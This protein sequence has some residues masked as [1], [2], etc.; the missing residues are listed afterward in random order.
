MAASNY[1]NLESRGYFPI[2][3]TSSAAVALTSTS[4]Q[5][6][7]AASAWRPIPNYAIIRPETG[8]IRW[9][10]DGTAPTAAVSGG[11]P[12]N[13]NETLEYDGEIGKFQFITTAGSATVNVNLYNAS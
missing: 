3:A 9:R 10:D 8:S 2:A 7:S 4:A 5:A 12:L 13:V 1:V 11:F 6:A